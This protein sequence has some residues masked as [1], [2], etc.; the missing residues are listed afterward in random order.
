[1]SGVNNP[2]Q[3]PY[4]TVAVSQTAQVLGTNGA[5]G[6]YLH[7]IVVTVSTAASSTVNIIDGSTTVL[8]IPANTPIGV[9]SLELGL[10]AA[11]GPWK[12]TTGA[13]AAVLA[14]GLFSK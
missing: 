9:Y 6:D 11:T 10:N 4:E 7:R 5:I 2:Y 8:A 13:G 3:Y 1:M 14:V 12:V